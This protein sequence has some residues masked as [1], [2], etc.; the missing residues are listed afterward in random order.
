[1]LDSKLIYNSNCV[2]RYWFF[3][4][5][6]LR[7]IYKLGMNKQFQY[8][9]AINMVEKK[10]TISTSIGFSLSTLQGTS[11]LAFAKVH[12]ILQDTESRLQAK[13]KV[14]AAHMQKIKIWLP[15][16]TTGVQS[17]QT[18]ESNLPLNITAK[19]NPALEV[20]IGLPNSTT[21]LIGLQT[22]PTTYTS[23]F[24]GQAQQEK[25]IKVRIGFFDFIE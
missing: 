23:D 16:V 22:L 10:T 12:S 9:M 15:I 14:N 8:A 7:T 3:I 4:V 18:I 19:L 25:I 6:R 1:M 24:T 21:Q 11:L 20:K 17:I 5:E 2:S 13:L